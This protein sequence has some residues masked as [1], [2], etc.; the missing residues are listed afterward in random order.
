MVASGML[1]PGKAKVRRMLEKSAEEDWAC[2]EE[3][4]SVPDH[5]LKRE[6]QEIGLLL[7]DSRNPEWT[8]RVKALQRF[9]AILAGGGTAHPNLVTLLRDHMREPLN[10]AIQDLRSAIS[11]E[12]CH[13]VAYLCK[14][15]PCGQWEVMSDWFLLALFKISVVTIAI[16]SQSSSRAL[17]YIVTKGRVTH[18][19]VAVVL[20]PLHYENKH[21]TYRQTVYQMMFTVLHKMPLAELTIRE[22]DSLTR[23]VRQGIIDPMPEVRKIARMLY[24][25]L[26]AVDT[27]KASDLAARLDDPTRKHLSEGR[28]LYDSIADY[29]NVDWEGLGTGAQTPGKAGA[30]SLSRA[31][32]GSTTPSSATRANAKLHH[33]P[34]QRNST[35]SLSAPE[36][37]SS[38]SAGWTMGHTESDGARS[39]SKAS[40]PTHARPGRAAPT[41]AQRRSGAAT[42][43][44]GGVRGARTPKAFAPPPRREEPASD[45]EFLMEDLLSGDVDL[46]PKAVPRI[47][48][49]NDRAAALAKLPQALKGPLSAKDVQLYFVPYIAEIMALVLEFLNGA[50]ADQ[51]NAAIDTATAIRAAI[52]AHPLMDSYLEDLY[53]ALFDRLGQPATHATTTQLLHLLLEKNRPRVLFPVLLRVLGSAKEHVQLGCLEYLLAL[54]THATEYLTRCGNHLQTGLV[55]F[56]SL[57]DSPHEKVSCAAAECI[58]VLYD[59]SAKQVCDEIARLPPADQE[60]VAVHLSH[61]IPTIEDDIAAA[62]R[63][64]PAPAADPAPPAARR[65]DPPP[66]L[67][68]APAGETG[69]PCRKPVMAL[70]PELLF[71][72]A[73]GRGGEEAAPA[74]AVRAPSLEGSDSSGQ[75]SAPVEPEPVSMPPMRVHTKRPTEKEGTTKARPRSPMARP[76]KQT[77]KAGSASRSAATTPASANAKA[78]AYWAILADA[79]A[80]PGSKLSA[81]QNLMALSKTATWLPPTA[82]LPQHYH[83]FFPVFCNDAHPLEL[84]MDIID[85]AKA[86]TLHLHSRGHESGLQEFFSFV[87]QCYCDPDPVMS[88]FVEATLHSLTTHPDALQ[89]CILLELQ[90]RGV[91]A[92]EQEEV[93]L[94][95]K[96]LDAL[97]NHLSQHAQEQLPDL[98]ATFTQTLYDGL[99]NERADVRKQCVFCFVSLYLSGTNTADVLRPLSTSQLKLI[100]I[101]VNRR[102]QGR[103]KKEITETVLVGGRD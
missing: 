98:V 37:D 58:R 86:L 19:T 63:R 59:V 9:R 24:W 94:L 81:A 54:M 96:L 21:S 68:A 34:S 80:T 95:F 38:S 31:V 92:R 90:H 22:I 47:L 27:Q 25:P 62:A 32:N 29:L 33:D 87:I 10:L 35:A 41:G 15:L 70:N 45:D 20:D 51:A 74:V 67:P 103:G 93:P 89:K 42:P 65:P 48:K 12:A 88:D 69:S 61:A 36:N 75:R 4:I 39:L 82:H 43:P 55:R 17:R 1:S 99:R 71:D 56:V 8:K 102:L 91:E 77:P 14:T 7:S 3:P 6:L 5:E 85:A 73:E 16:I 83:G 44:A 18:R 40:T 60:R 50:D 52:P 28:F 66:V 2:P 76:N 64:A 13:V 101:Y 57:T 97:I 23:A 46:S 72:S 49:M 26:R 53:L 11:K 100:T 84:R 79:T 78:S 30:R